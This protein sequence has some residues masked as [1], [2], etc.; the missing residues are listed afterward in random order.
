MLKSKKKQNL[1]KLTVVAAVLVIAFLLSGSLNSYY[2]TIFN[3]T[4]IYFLCTASMSLIF[5]MGGQLSYC[6]VTFMGLGAFITAKATTTF[7]LTPVI[8]MV[9]G[10]LISAAVAFVFSLVLVK[11]RGAFFTFGTL[12]LVN[13]GGTVYQNFTPLTGGSEGTAGIPKLT[14]LGITFD[15]LKAWFFLLVVITFLAFALIQRIRTS[16]LGRSLMA[17]RDDEVAAQT[18][19]INVYRTKVIAFTISSALA[20]FSGTLVALHNGVVSPSL[21]TFSVQTKFIIMSMLGGINS[22][23]GALLGTALLQLLPEY[24]RFLQT[25]AMLV[26][27]VGIVLLLVFMPTGIMGLLEAGYKKLRKK[28]KAEDLST[29]EK[30]RTKTGGEQ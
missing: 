25:Y 30:E 9:L 20:A 19:G 21:F 14:L 23:L 26:Y 11:M 15:N 2:M 27:G 28:G 12:A 16:S 17:V 4:L 22:T 7:G 24:L 8:G 29:D 13:I 5:G 18:L 10:V 1:I 3:M 6:T